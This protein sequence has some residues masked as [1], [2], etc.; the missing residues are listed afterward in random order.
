MVVRIVAMSNYFAVA[1]R[2]AFARLQYASGGHKSFALRRIQEVQLVLSRQNFS[3]RRCQAEGGVAARRIGDH[4]GNRRVH[5]PMLLH[6][7]RVERRA[8]DHFAGLDGIHRSTDARH[9]GLA[10]EAVAHALFERNV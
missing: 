8:D 2:Q 7:T 6:E 1:N 4:G 9:R 10:G 5:I 3:A